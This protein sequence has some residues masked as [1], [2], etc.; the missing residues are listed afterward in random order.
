MSVSSESIRDSEDER[1]LAIMDE[2][3]RPCPRCG[4]WSWNRHDSEESCLLALAEN[5]L[6]S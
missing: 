6:E 5:V 1:I 3:S 2:I 4:L